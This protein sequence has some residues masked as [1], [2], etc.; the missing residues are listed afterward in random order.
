MST[1]VSLPVVADRACA[2]AV[3]RDPSPH[4]RETRFSAR[5]LVCVGSVSHR[6]DGACFGDSG[7]PL[8]ENNTA[9]GQPALWGITSY[10]PQ[11]GAGLAA[12]S[13]DL[14]AVYTLVPAYTSFIQSMPTMGIRRMPDGAGISKMS[15]TCPPCNRA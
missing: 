1:R 6:F 12:C 5:Y 7:G 8:V 2:Q 15:P 11:E 9:T 10:G 13:T 14:P 4:A 3:A